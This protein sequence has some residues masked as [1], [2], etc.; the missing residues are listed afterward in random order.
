MD[1][2]SADAMNALQTGTLGD[3]TGTNTLVYS[4]S[5]DEQQPPKKKSK[6]DDKQHPSSNTTAK[7]DA[8]KTVSATS[9]P[10]P[11]KGTPPPPDQGTIQAWPPPEQ[12]NYQDLGLA[13]TSSAIVTNVV[14]T[15]GAV[16]GFSELKAAMLGVDVFEVAANGETAATKLGREMHAL[17]KAGLADGETTFKEFTGIKGIRPDFVDFGTKTIYELKPNNIRA[18]V[19]GVDQLNTYKAAFETQYGGT[20][21]IVLDTY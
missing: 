12:V 11:L 16:A 6:A 17:Y 15:Y 1:Q 9:K 21:N 5:G 8:A 10:Q 2:A 7:A 13:S 14:N 3:G 19:Q 20:W 4:A 18:I